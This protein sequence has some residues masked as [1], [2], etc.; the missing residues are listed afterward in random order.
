M[1]LLYALLHF[2]HYWG[3]GRQKVLEKS[4][5]AIFIKIHE[6]FVSTY[7]YSTALV[8]CLSFLRG[9]TDVLVTGSMGSE[10]IK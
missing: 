9:A 8:S 6:I 5:V 4:K 7:E 3:S 2:F 10:Y 1:L